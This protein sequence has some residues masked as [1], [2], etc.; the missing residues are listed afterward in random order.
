MLSSEDKKTRAKLLFP[1][2]GG[3]TTAG[4]VSALTVWFFASV[5]KLPFA[6]DFPR[7]CRK[8]VQL[9]ENLDLCGM[10]RVLGK[11]DRERILF[12]I[13][14]LS[15]YHKDSKRA[16]KYVFDITLVPKNFRDFSSRVRDTLSFVRSFVRSFVLFFFFVF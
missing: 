1:L 12:E 15:E 8:H 16:G 10:Y 13:R 14:K 7:F 4:I 3:D 6:F 9:I 5:R 2:L 11:P